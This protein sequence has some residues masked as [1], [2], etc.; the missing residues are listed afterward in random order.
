MNLFSTI[1]SKFGLGSIGSPDV[2]E[3]ISGNRSR[4][5]EAGITVNDDKALNLSAVWACSRIITQSVSGLPLNFFKIRGS[6]ERTAL[7][8]DHYLWRIFNLSPNSFMSPQDFREAMTLQRVLWGNAYAKVEWNSSETE[9]LSI[10]P[11]RPEHMQV[12]R[13]STGLVYHYSTEKGIVVYSQQSIFHLKGFS[14]DGVMGLS[15][16]AYSRNTMGI[17]VSADTYA[18][19]S[20]ANGGIPGGVLT[21]DKFLNNDQRIEAAKLYE[22]ISAT[23]NNA[24]KLWV[25]EGGSKYEP[26][27]ISPDDMQMLQTRSFQLSEIARF[28]G[29]PSHLINDTEKST[30]WGTGLEQLDLGFLKYTLQSYLTDWEDAI[31]HQL[32]PVSERRK[33]VAEHDVEDFLRTDAKTRAE[34]NSINSQNGIMSR[35]EARKTINLPR[36][37]GADE[38]TAQ[39]NLVPL[40]KL[41]EQNAQDENTNGDVPAQV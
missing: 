9:V 27:S 5:T 13:S 23:A 39:V 40:D 37:E 15:P 31:R 2:G 30:S 25:L 29:V 7:S 28:Y 38:L 19:K 36:V 10:T 33:L 11:L 32:M 8:Q 4:S 22:G 16:L 41:G 18:S 6:G 34:V 20:F 14:V 17:A 1:L 12:F 21:F 26:I 35:N 24:N 3:Q